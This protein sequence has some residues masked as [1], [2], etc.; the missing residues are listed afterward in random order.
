MVQH[1]IQ[2]LYPLAKNTKIMLGVVWVRC[3]VSNQY[4]LAI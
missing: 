2:D 3:A 1:E 4:S